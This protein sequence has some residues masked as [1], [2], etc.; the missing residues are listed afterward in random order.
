VQLHV[1]VATQNAAGAP[2]RHLQTL[3]TW[4]IPDVLFVLRFASASPLGRRQM[5]GATLFGTGAILVNPQ[6]ASARKEVSDGGLPPGIAE[7][8]GV[9]KA[10][11][12]WTQIG[13]R[14]CCR[15]S[16]MRGL[17]LD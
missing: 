4:L 15:R 9:V 2:S 14:E 5:L 10:K 13:K 8:M 12:Q 16:E 3:N 11:K 1:S 7:Y 6:V 17:D